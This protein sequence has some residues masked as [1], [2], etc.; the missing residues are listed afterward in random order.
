MPTDKNLF[1]LIYT[2]A[3]PHGISIQ[4][5]RSYKRVDVTPTKPYIFSQKDNKKPEAFNYYERLASRL[6]I[7]PL[8]EG[9]EDQLPVVPDTRFI[10]K[11]P[12][13][14]F[15]SKRNEVNEANNSGTTVTPNATVVSEESK[16]EEKPQE[17]KKESTDEV[18]PLLKGEHPLVPVT[19]ELR[20]DIDSMFK[21]LAKSIDEADINMKGISD[22]QLVEM[23][24]PVANPQIVKAMA[25]HFNITL[26]SSR[27]YPKM[28]REIVTNGNATL[29]EYINMY[30]NPEKVARD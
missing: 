6:H 24:E 1:A 9:Q 2:G 21:N 27:S 29:V 15:E 16:K 8:V 23:F 12:T 13:T 4:L 20:N 11:A 25:K 7:K 5:F 28:V 18:G 22:D 3:R 17:D 14:P 19:E 26:T 30:R 10:H